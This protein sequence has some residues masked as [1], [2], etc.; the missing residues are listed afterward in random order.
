M[1]QGSKTLVAGITVATLAAATARAAEPVTLTLKDHRFT[2]DHF[3]VPSGQRFR[4]V[5]TNQDDTTDEFE[6]YD[7]KF[8]KIVVPGGK[9]SVFAGPLRPGTYRFFDDYHPDIAT[10]T[11][12]ATGKD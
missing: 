2:P 5:L 8:E 9:I 7:L 3:E 1:L 6:S 10:G 12:T 4:I 11:V